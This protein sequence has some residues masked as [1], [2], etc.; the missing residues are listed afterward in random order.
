MPHNQSYY[1]LHQV[2]LK[3]SLPESHIDDCDIDNLMRKLI[4]PWDSGR[5]IMIGYN[6]DPEVDEYYFIKGTKLAMDFREQAGIHPDLRL[7]D[8][9]AGL[10]TAVIALLLSFHLK[11]IR[12]C[13]LAGEQYPQIS[14]YHSLT[15]WSPKAEFIKNI[16]VYC[17]MAEDQVMAILLPGAKYSMIDYA[18]Y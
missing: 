18:A 17:D 1:I 15:K 10:V 11:H 14:F 16:S 4:F 3:N 12:F 5:G 2:I 7:G 13:Q 6:A 8:L 9:N